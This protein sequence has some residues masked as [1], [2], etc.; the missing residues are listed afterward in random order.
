MQVLSFLREE[1]GLEVGA[2]EITSTKTL[3]VPAY[4]R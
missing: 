1:E 4:K 3:V 2:L